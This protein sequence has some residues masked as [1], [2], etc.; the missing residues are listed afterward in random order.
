MNEIK[1]LET[2]EQLVDLQNSL[3][4]TYRKINIELNHESI[5]LAGL[6]V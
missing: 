6:T 5:A 4:T 3:P 2:T 1:K